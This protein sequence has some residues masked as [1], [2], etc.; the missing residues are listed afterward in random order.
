MTPVYG[1]V[2]WRF[3]GACV[4][5]PDPDRWYSLAEL[6]GQVGT[7]TTIREL[8]AICASCPVIAQ[9]AAHALA[10][11]NF[12]V[13]AGTTPNERRKLRRKAGIVLRDV[14]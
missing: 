4:D 12:G 10:Y 14:A 1:D 13:W 6:N 3:E 5:D 8:R 7:D 11:E 9:C 2:R